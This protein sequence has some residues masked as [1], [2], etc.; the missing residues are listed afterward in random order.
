MKQTSPVVEVRSV[1]FDLFG[2]VIS[3]DEGS[4]YRRLAVHCGEPATAFAAL[5]GLVSTPELVTGRLS[6]RQLHRQLVVAHGL[7]LDYGAFHESWLTPYT[8]AMPGIA[9][10]LGELGSRCR[11][12]LLSNVDRY[13]LDVVRGLHRELDNFDVQLFSCELGVAKPGSAAFTAALRAAK[14]RPQECYFID[15]K[16]ENVHAAGRLGV[17]GHVF[18]NTQAL[19]AA[20]IEKRILAG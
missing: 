5:Q 17:A 15:D 6:L 12:V 13:Y 9:S 4:V 16:R 7:A 2:V 14:A 3:F 11:L 19:R 8:A 10:L 1:I 20:L 18:R